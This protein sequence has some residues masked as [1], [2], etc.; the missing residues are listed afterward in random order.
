M[1]R[2]YHAVSIKAALGESPATLSRQLAGIPISLIPCG[3]ASMPPGS[4]I[5]EAVGWELGTLLGPARTTTV[6]VGGQVHER[7]DFTLG[8]RARRERR[9]QGPWR[10]RP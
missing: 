1:N 3:M 2:D 10:E 8:S 9:V 7:H 5:H 6:F 4:R